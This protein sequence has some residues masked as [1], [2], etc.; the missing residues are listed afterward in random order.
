[1]ALLDLLAAGAKE[2]QLT[3]TAAH[4]NHGW[5]GD[6]AYE[7]TVRAALTRYDLPLE[8]GRGSTGRS[9]AAAR[10]GRYG[11]LRELKD[12]LGADAIITAHHLDDLEETVILNVQRGTGRRGLTPFMSTPDVLRPLATIRKS[13]LETY[14][15]QHKLQWCH[16]TYNDDLVFARNRVRHEQLPQLRSDNPQFDDEF[17][18]ILA[19]AGELNA[20]IDTELRALFIVREYEA[21]IKNDLIR[22]LDLSVITELLIMMVNSICPG[23]ELSKR[24]IEQLAVDLKTGRLKQPRDLKNGLSVVHAR[25]TVTIVF[26]P[27]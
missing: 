24:T 22:Q 10:A 25:D 2:H 18:E 12:R 23:T 21:T 3:L 1:M 5:E 19:E 7:E 13:E 8:V 14:A 17:R 20:E 11:F 15:Q 26:R 16:D 27:L 6:D 4:F 9:E